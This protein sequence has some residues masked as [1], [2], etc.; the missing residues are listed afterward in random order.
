MLANLL[1]ILACPN[2]HG[3]FEL[4]VSREEQGDIVEGYLTCEICSEVYPIEGSIPNLLP[5]NL[6]EARS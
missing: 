4:V 5:K 3:P 6:R 2:D 1:D